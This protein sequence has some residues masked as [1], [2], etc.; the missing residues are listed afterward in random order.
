MIEIKNLKDLRAQ[1]GKPI[2]L[3]YGDYPTGCFCWMGVLKG[4][5]ERC[6]KMDGKELAKVCK[7]FVKEGI[8]DYV[9][10]LCLYCE[11]QVVM[12]DYD[13]GMCSSKYAAEID[14]WYGDDWTGGGDADFIRVPTEEEL[15]NYNKKIKEVPKMLKTLWEDED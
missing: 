15:N 7:E 14:A 4:I 2:L 1:I 10:Q 6:E 11:N 8:T 9:S 12:Y 13:I 3:G 5:G